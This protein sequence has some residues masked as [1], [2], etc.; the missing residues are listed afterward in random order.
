MHKLLPAP[1]DPRPAK[2]AGQKSKNKTTGKSTGNYLD[3]HGI[4]YK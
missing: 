3:T 4:E 1:G 2:A